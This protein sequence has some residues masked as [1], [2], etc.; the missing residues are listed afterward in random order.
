M[1]EGDSDDLRTV[2]INVD[3]NTAIVEGETDQVLT[4]VSLLGQVLV[5]DGPGEEV[6]GG[7]D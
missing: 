5:S 3:R 7:V 1:F 4:E 6:D 2:L